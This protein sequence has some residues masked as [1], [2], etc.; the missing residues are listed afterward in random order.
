[1][2]ACNVLHVNVYMYL[3]VCVCVRVTVYVCMHV[4]VQMYVCMLI[5]MY[6]VCLCVCVCVSTLYTTHTS[7]DGDK[8]AAA[9]LNDVVASHR[10]CVCL[11]WVKHQRPYATPCCQDIS[12]PNCATHTTHT[13]HTHKYTHVTAIILASRRE[14]T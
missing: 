14:P 6:G 12:S 8:S 5:I 7:R 3:C 13:H 11:V 2:Q 10:L 4:C 9:D 1:M